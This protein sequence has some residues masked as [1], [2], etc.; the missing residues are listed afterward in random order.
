M[1]TERGYEDTVYEEKKF[2]VIKPHDKSQGKDGN[3]REYYNDK[4]RNDKS[5]TAI[6]ILH[7]LF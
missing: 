7:L 1:F 2:E 6:P 5:Y 4:S 3:S